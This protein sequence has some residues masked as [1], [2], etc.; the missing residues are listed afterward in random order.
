MRLCACGLC[1]RMFRALNLRRLYAPEC[2]NRA[3]R[4]ASIGRHIE[5]RYQA[6][7]AARLRARWAA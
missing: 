2:P 3:R 7:R 5:A 6:A 4:Q 1:G